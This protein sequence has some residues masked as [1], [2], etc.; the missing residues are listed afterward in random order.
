MWVKIADFGVSKCTESTVLRTQVMSQGY[1][2]PEMLGLL[3]I[4]NTTYSDGIDIWALGCVAHEMLTGQIPFLD[5]TPQYFDSE[6]S[7]ETMADDELTHDTDTTALKAFCD[8]KIA[9]PT[10]RMRRAGVSAVAEECVMAMLVAVPNARISAQDALKSEWLRPPVD[11]VGVVEP[12]SEQQSKSKNMSVSS[13]PSYRL[14]VD[15]LPILSLIV[16]YV[17]GKCVA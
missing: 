5:S 16:G 10:E 4:A 7:L 13:C 15:R 17:V 11:V 6:L 2:S 1:A 12:N 9:F 8:D 3:T 14:L